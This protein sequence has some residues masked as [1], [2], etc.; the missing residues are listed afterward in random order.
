MPGVV[1]ACVGRAVE[2]CTVGRAVG[3]SEGADVR[4]FVSVGNRVGCDVL[5]EAKDSGIVVGAEIG[6]SVG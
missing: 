3:S 6:S 1:G 4:L 5:Y 2:G